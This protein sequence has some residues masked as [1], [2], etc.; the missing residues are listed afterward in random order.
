MF[1]TVFGVLSAL[2]QSA[3]AGLLPAWAA[4]LP[5]GLLELSGGADALARA[6]L[7]Q[8]V[9]FIGASFFLAFGGLSVHAQTKAVLHAAGLDALPVFVPKLLHA[10]AA[11]LLSVPVYLLFQDRLDAAPAFA[12]SAPAGIFW[13]SG[14]VFAASVFLLFRK[15]AGSNLQQDRV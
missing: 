12:W 13:L 1:V 8:G 4:F 5:A 6:P 15:M 9:K 2:I 14:P 7:S 11:A 3:L 10:L